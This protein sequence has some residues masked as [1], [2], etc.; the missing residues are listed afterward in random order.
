LSAGDIPLRLLQLALT[1]II[2]TICS[3]GLFYELE[4]NLV[5]GKH[6]D[7]MFHDAI[8]WAA[9]TISTVSHSAPVYHN[10]QPCIRWPARPR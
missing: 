4:S 2:L 7:L 6:H 10:L 3:A 5:G 9:V 1:V 8:Y